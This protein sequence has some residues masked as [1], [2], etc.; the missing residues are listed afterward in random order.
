A[1]GFGP[2]IF[3]FEKNETVYTVRLLPLGGYVRMAGEDAETV[4]LKP[5][6]KVGLVLNEKE[7]VIKLVLDGREKYPNVRVIEVEQAD[8]EHNLTISGYEEYEE[9]LQTFRVNETA[10]I[11][12]AGEEIQ[13]APFNRQFGSK[14]LGQRALT[15]FAG[16]A[17]NF[18]LAFVIFIIIGLVQGIPVDKPMIGKVMKDSVA[19]QA[20]LKQD[21]TIQAID[22]KDT[23]TWKDVV[24]IVRENPNREITLHVK[25]DS[26]QFNV[27]VTPSVDTEGKEK[28]GRIGVYSPVEKSIF[29]SIK[30]AFEQTYTWTKLIFDSLVKLVTGQFSINDL[31]GPVGIYNLTDQV[32]DYGVIRV[33]NLAAVLSIN[34][35]LFNLLPVPALDGG[36]L[37]FFLIEALRGKPIDR[38]KEGMVH[39][40]GFALL[41]LLMLVVTWNDIRKFFL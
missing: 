18:I 30:S 40:I 34:L 15:I 1:I 3:S 25:R 16:P 19:E 14:T 38:Q 10:R 5:G 28:V 29:G 8:L 32:V 24:T 41:M 9:E 26:E 22:G 12:S 36:R 7:E 17:M 21:D 4:E 11:I 33:L 23:N 35:G 27:K 37:F 2:K 13:I 31:S 6:K 20:G 39:F